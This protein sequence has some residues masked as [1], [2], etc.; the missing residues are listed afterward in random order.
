MRTKTKSETKSRRQQERDLERRLL[1]EIR[2]LAQP[3]TAEQI[4]EIA[5]DKKPIHF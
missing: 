4:I 1:Q 3:V 2:S 5:L